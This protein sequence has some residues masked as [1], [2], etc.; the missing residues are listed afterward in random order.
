MAARHEQAK[1][2]DRA[3]RLHQID[4]DATSSFELGGALGDRRREI[5]DIG[6]QALR[7]REMN[8]V[9]GRKY[10]VAHDPLAISC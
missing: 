1:G 5:V 10:P 3:Q 4:R 9:F 7:W 2:A 6:E 8:E